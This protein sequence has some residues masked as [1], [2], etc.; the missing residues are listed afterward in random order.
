VP[1]IV[2]PVIDVWVRFF[3]FMDSLFQFDSN[4]VILAKIYERLY[5]GF[6]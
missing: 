1:N 4:G 5:S 2:L 6:A 3:G